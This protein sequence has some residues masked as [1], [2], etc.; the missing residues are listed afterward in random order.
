[1]KGNS[2]KNYILI[3]DSLTYGIGDLETLGWS[4]MFKKDAV[5]ASAKK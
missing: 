3:G 1:M 2:M 5:E 4:S